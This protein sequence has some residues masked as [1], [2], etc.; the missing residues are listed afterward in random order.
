MSKANVVLNDASVMKEFLESRAYQILL[1]EWNRCKDVAMETLLNMSLDEVKY[2]FK[3]RQSNV[4]MIKAW[5][6]LPNAIIKKY[7]VDAANKKQEEEL[8]VTR[9]NKECLQRN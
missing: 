8:L 5:I 6:D 2:P 9:H 4:N 3:T 7:E 1:D